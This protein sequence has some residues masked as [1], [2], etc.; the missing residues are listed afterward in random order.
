MANSVTTRQVQVELRFLGSGT[1]VFERGGFHGGVPAPET[2]G[3][4]SFTL[5]HQTA[6]EDGVMI[7]TT[8]ASGLQQ[9]FQLNIEGSSAGFAELGRYFL[10][11]SA[12]DTVRDPDF[13]E[14]FDDVMSSDGH[15]VVDIIVRKG[16]Q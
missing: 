12:L 11:L 15:T 10:A 16:P 4:V 6:D 13:H 14:H 9:S 5:H 1:V 3:E 8:L 2:K 7:P